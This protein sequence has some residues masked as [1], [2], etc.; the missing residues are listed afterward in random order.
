MPIATIRPAR[1]RSEQSAY[2][3]A[4]RRFG[5]DSAEAKMAEAVY[6]T[7]RL[8]TLIEDAIALHPL[9]TEQREQIAH[10]ALNAL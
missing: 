7:I 9:T 8:C 10:A 3:N 2:S 1:G 5:R 6:W 4:V